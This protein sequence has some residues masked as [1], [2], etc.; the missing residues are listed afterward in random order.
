MGV[1]LAAGGYPFSFVLRDPEVEQV[2]N[3]FRFVLSRH[4]VGIVSSLP[5]R[6]ATVE[7]IRQLRENN[8]LCIL[9][10]QRETQGG[11]FVDFFGRPAGT[12]TGP[13]VL[14]MRTQAVI[15]PVFSLRRP[16]DELVVVVEPAFQLEDSGDRE[17]DIYANTARLTKIIERYVSEYPSQWFWLH[18]RWKK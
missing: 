15:L 10:D 2:A 13:V 12:A 6:R 4:G 17:K 16:N 1:R 5:R 14:A 9:G 7:S 11:V 3:V 8:I 18:K